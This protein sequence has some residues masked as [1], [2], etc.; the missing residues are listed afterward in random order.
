[1]TTTINGY[2]KKPV[3]VQETVGDVGTHVKHWAKRSRASTYTCLI[4]L[5]VLLL[6]VLSGR[7]TVREGVGGGARIQG[8]IQIQEHD[9]S[10]QASWQLFFKADQKLSVALGRGRSNEGSTTMVD[11]PNQEYEED[12]LHQHGEHRR[13]SCQV[14]GRRRCPLIGGSSPQRQRRR[15]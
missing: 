13:W 9:W 2:E 7:Y 6:F 4:T 14:L 8:G 3:V 5:I 1:M 12:G 15:R 11:N 10:I